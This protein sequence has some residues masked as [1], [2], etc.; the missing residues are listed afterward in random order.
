MTHE[1]RVQET[2]ELLQVGLSLAQDPVAY[3]KGMLLALSVGADQD[4][5]DEERKIL[6]EYVET[7]RAAS[8]LAGAAEALAPV[9]DGLTRHGWDLDALAEYDYDIGAALRSLGWVPP[10]ERHPL[11]VQAIEAARAEEARRC[12]AVCE[13]VAMLSGCDSNR[14]KACRQCAATIIEVRARVKVPSQEKRPLVV[15]L[16][17]STRFVDAYMEAYA[18]ET[19]A[20]RIVLSVGRFKPVHGWDD[21]KKAK[22]DA[23]HLRKIDLADEILVLNVGGYIGDST[24]REID[25]AQTHGKNVRWLEAQAPDAGRV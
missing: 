8:R 7:T 12:A 25:Y 9:R 11:N 17:G 16:C 14:A 13:S 19:D 10:A 5:R 2:T 1:E 22:L 3:L 24:R 18:S 4:A 6:S 23:L 20:G 15:C 21:A